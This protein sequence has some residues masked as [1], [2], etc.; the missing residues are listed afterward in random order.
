MK[1]LIICVLG[2]LLTAPL[3]AAEENIVSPRYRVEVS[4]AH[5]GIKTIAFWAFPEQSKLFQ[6]VT[7][8]ADKKLQGNVL[9]IYMGNVGEEEFLWKIESDDSVKMIHL[10][11]KPGREMTLQMGDQTLQITLGSPS[12]QD[13]VRPDTPLLIST[14]AGIFKH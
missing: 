14:C 2:L 6:I 13:L 1:N 9:A 8:D 4:G 7:Y 3:E 12:D 10:L 5:E 11:R